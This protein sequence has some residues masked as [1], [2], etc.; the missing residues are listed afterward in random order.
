MNPIAS[1]GKTMAAI[2]AAGLLGIAT[3]AAGREIEFSPAGVQLFDFEKVQEFQKW[4]V[5]DLTEFRQTTRWAASGKAAAAVTFH[6]WEPGKERWPAVLALRR[7][8]ALPITDFSL[9]DGLAFQAFN[10]QKEPVV[11]RLHLRDGQGRRFSQTFT[12]PPRRAVACEIALSNLSDRL[13]ISRIVELHFFVTEPARTY[14]V[15]I[16]DVRLTLRTPAAAR[17]LV[18]RALALETEAEVRLR[19]SSGALP[20]SIGRWMRDLEEVRVQAQTIRRE[21]EEGR[22]SAWEALASVR[23][24]L[25][26]L[27]ARLDAA[28]AVLPCLDA[29]EA[30]RLTGVRGFVLAAESP[31]KKVF[32]EAGRFRSPFRSEYAL[33][34]ARNEYESFQVIVFPVQHELRNVRCR[35]VSPLAGP[36]GARVSATVRLVGYVFCKQPSYEVPHTGWWPDPLLDFTDTVERVP[37]GEVAVFWITVHVPEDAPAGL[38]RGALEVTAESVPAQRFG[39]TL[40]VWDFA[41]PKHTHLRTAL[42]FRSLAKVYPPERLAEMTR[43][44]ENWMLN[45]YH[46]NPGSIYSGPPDWDADRLRELKRL[47][48]NAINLTYLNAPR[49]S[50]FDAAKYWRTFEDRVRRVEKWLPVVEAADVRD[51]CY[52]YCF[53]ERPTDQ[54]DVVFETAARLKQK[55]PDIE[56]MT[57]AYDPTFGLDRKNGDAVDIWVPLT[58]HFD[59]N[60]E[61]IAQARRAGRQVWWYICIGPQ[62][63]YA[64]WFIEYPAIEARLIM[65]AMTAKYRPDGFLYYAVNRWPVNDHPIRSGPRTD[66]NPASYKNNNGDGSIMC[67]GPNGPLATVRL[68][69]IRDGIEDY[70]YY[71]LLRRLLARRNGRVKKESGGGPFRSIGRFF[72]RL[73]MGG[74]RSSEKT[75]DAG[76]VSEEVVAEL[77]HY[78]RSPEVLL[79]ERRRVAALI[80][81]LQDEAS[82]GSP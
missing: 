18:Y 67:A 3:G 62:H 51:L 47:G 38:Y 69:N 12:L 49:G 21:F 8:D 16:D 30:A 33:E 50:K 23:A 52:I 39:M 78:T 59:S 13:D 43:K 37:F 20:A 48:L 63:P 40:T 72:G 2:F 60:A 71:H 36:G 31:M 17:S 80:L 54:L 74:V 9:F 57:T 42:S 1:N 53:D 28:R 7:K 6:K 11:V 44:Y 32:L 82:R 66:W 14:T 76:R 34:A 24:R 56:V 29:L 46:L 15:Y 10:P 35:I 25:K 5:R 81:A 77:T 58:P 19:R 4:M 75:G 55:W 61:R 26:T 27:Q 73:I 70:E 22:Y 68:E 41:I 79:A 65:G 64:N 45:E